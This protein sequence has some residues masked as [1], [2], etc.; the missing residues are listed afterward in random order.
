MKYLSYLF[1][2]VLTLTISDVPMT[3]RLLK[4]CLPDAGR[5]TGVERCPLAPPAISS[6]WHVRAQRADSDPA[7]PVGQT[8]DRETLTPDRGRWRMYGQ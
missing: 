1:L 7:C 8:C 4:W 5:P 6:K 3:A 2:L